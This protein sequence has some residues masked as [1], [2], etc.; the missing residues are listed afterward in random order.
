MWA[1]AASRSWSMNV[2]WT[3]MMKF[4]PCFLH[5]RQPLWISRMHSSPSPLKVQ[6]HEEASCPAVHIVYIQRCSINLKMVISMSMRKSHMEKHLDWSDQIFVW[7]YP[8]AFPACC[9]WHHFTLIIYNHTWLWNEQKKNLGQFS[10][11]QSDAVCSMQLHSKVRAT[12][13][14]F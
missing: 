13:K 5:S 8:D 14:S 4:S 11:N 10:C 9:E 2:F 1:A 7:V 12:Q 6:P 3:L